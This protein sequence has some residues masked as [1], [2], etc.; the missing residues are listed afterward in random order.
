[1]PDVLLGRLQFCDALGHLFLLV[2]KLL[3]RGSK[4]LKLLLRGGKMLLLGS[5]LLYAAPREGETYSGDRQLL[6][7][8]YRQ[9]LP[10]LTALRAISGQAISDPA[11]ILRVEA[12]AYFG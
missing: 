2:S 7:D 12:R 6:R 4:L 3:L 8:R 11:S 1:M 10:R 5:E 9:H